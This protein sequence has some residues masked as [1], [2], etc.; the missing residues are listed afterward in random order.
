MDNEVLDHVM[1]EFESYVT[2]PDLS[3]A[4]RENEGL[5]AVLGID[6][7]SENELG[8]LF[9]T[10]DS[11]GDNSISRA[12]WLEFVTAVLARRKGGA[13]QRSL[14]SPCESNAV[15]GATP[16]PRMQSCRA[17][18]NGVAAG[19]AAMWLQP[20]KQLRVDA[21]CGGLKPSECSCLMKGRGVTGERGSCI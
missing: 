19:V 17:A 10:L 5:V 13:E 3:K 9:D 11:D 16:T 15:V 8:A 7:C 6:P 12:E 2:R 4:V 20:S 18:W 14:Q 21:L 1:L